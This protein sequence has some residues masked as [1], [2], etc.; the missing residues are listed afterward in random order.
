MPRSPRWALVALVSAC[1]PAAQVTPPTVVPPKSPA[2]PVRPVETP[3]RWLFTPSGA[4]TIDV[5]LDLGTQ[6]VLYV[7]SGGERWLD[8]KGTGGLVPAA[9][10]LPSDLRGVARTAAGKF[11]FVAANGTVSETDAPLGPIKAQRKPKA[12]LRLATPG[13]A[14]IVAVDGAGQLVRST[15]GGATWAPASAPKVTGMLTNLAMHPNGLGLA[16][17]AP[18]QVLAS[19]DDGAT[20]KVVGT[21]GI[22]ARRVALDVNGELVLDGVLGSA[23]LAQG[24]LRLERNASAAHVGFD[25]PVPEGAVTLEMTEALR[26]GRALLLEDRYLEVSPDPDGE[27]R[28]RLLTVDLGPKATSATPKV[29]RMPELDGCINTAIGGHS[30]QI[31]LACDRQ[32]D[33]TQ[34]PKYGKPGW[35]WNPPSYRPQVHLL[36]S[37]DGGEKWAADGWI[38]GGERSERYL[39]VSPEGV[40]LLDG[41]CKRGHL[42]WVCDDSPPV[43]RL[44][45]AKG[46]AKATSLQGTRFSAVTFGKQNAFALGSVQGGPTL[47]F[48]SKNGGKDFSR[49]ALTPVGDPDDP[50]G[51]LQL[52]A[53]GTV[54]VEDS[55]VVVYSSY[56]RGLVRWVSHDDG[57]TFKGSVVPLPSAQY[58][59][60]AGKRALAWDGVATAWETA[61]G[62]DTWTEVTGAAPSVIVSTEHPI[63]CTPYGCALAGRGVRVGWDLAAGAAGPI[64]ALA[65]AAEPKRVARTGIDCTQTGEWLVEGNLPLPGASHSDLGGDTRWVLARRDPKTNAVV[66]VVQK[67]DGKGALERKEIA[68]FAPDKSVDNAVTAVMQVEGVA[69]LKYS[70]KREK[71]AKT[72]TA[73]PAPAKPITAP[74]K[75]IMKP[76]PPPPMPAVPAIVPKQTVDVEIAWYVA[77]TGKVHKGTLKGVGPLDPVRDVVDGRLDPSQARPFLLSIAPGGIHV[78]PLASSQPDQPLWFVSDA[79]KVEKLTWPDIPQKDVR[80]RNLAFHYD[81]TRIGKRTVVLADAYPAHF[82]VAWANEAGGAWESRLWS[83]WPEADLPGVGMYRFVDSGVGAGAALGLFYAGSAAHAPAA[84]GFVVKGTLDDD[85]AN[86]FALPTQKSVGDPPKACGALAKDA[87][88]FNVPYS[89]GTRHPVIVHG[90]GLDRVLATSN[91]I[92]RVPAAGGTDACVTMI[93]AAPYPGSPGDAWTALLPPGD[94]EHATLFRT[95]YESGQY[96]MSSRPLKCAWSKDMKLPDPL[97]KIAGF[98]ED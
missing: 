47:L 45:G 87:L 2:K 62:G 21:P 89:T 90:D 44:P 18:Q 26:T 68:L 36:K 76:P 56:G 48:V 96:K 1:S 49:R 41:G 77:A 74:A 83:L 17:L 63:A 25:L 91:A 51:L 69:A 13:K 92:L 14:A 31:E 66:A 71:P 12:P 84:F 6:G 8:T 95:R 3:A 30:G 10:V 78:R 40:L 80:G 72:A 22:G 59:G 27:N 58:V 7:G 46:V 24:P 55:F 37:V 64:K 54:A 15:D 57:A 32:S 70:F 42:D 38:P 23:R 29:K 73:T 50:K 11:H 19:D 5:R 16:L 61:D 60:A 53:S 28:H 82:Y 65:A 20:W 35:G 79:G 94:L 9:T 75:S 33:A 97:T 52:E 81:A 98:T 4:A 88:R 43:V 86:L 67:P 93:E 34:P 39:W 85:P